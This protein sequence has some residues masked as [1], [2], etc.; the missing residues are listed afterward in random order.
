VSGIQR[1]DQEAYFL[2]I[3][4]KARQVTDLPIIL[5]GGFRSREVMERVLDEGTADFISLCRPLIREPDLPNRIRDGQAAAT[6]ISCNQCWPRAGELG[7]S[8]HYQPKP[9]QEEDE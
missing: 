6:C 3:A 8:C 2:P 1:P 4:R 7:I 9:E 5:V